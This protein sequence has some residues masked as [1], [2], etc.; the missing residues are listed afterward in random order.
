[1]MMNHCA[2]RFS[3][4]K[5]T[6]PF[7]EFCATSKA[8]TSTT[9]RA[10][11]IHISSQGFISKN[12]MSAQA[13]GDKNN[14]F[15]WRLSTKMSNLPVVAFE[16]IVALQRF[17]MPDY[18]QDELH[19]QDWAQTGRDRETCSQKSVEGSH[20]I[21]RKKCNVNVLKGRKNVCKS[22]LPH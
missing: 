21:W 4:R 7:L 12:I 20:S 14:G 22:S 11:L 13:N 19:K 2:F 1:M 3:P 15:V 17:N 9:V 5:Q 16:T 18:H 10:I 8:R 6:N